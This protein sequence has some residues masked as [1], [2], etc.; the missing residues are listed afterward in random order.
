VHCDNQRKTDIEGKKNVN[1][2]AV[3]QPSKAVKWKP[4]NRAL[5]VNRG[6]EQMGTRHWNRHTCVKAAGDGQEPLKSLMVPPSTSLIRCSV[7]KGNG[8]G[9]R[10]GQTKEKSP[11][12]TIT[13]SERKETS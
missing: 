11:T 1:Y 2:G 5:I 9:K 12:T 13:A 7:R 6:P 3:N 8:A 4:Q 10:G